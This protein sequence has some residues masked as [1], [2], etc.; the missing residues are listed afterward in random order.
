MGEGRYKITIEMVA[1]GFVAHVAAEDHRECD[2][3]GTYVFEGIDGLLEFI[4]ERCCKT[5]DKS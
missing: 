1:N 3:N 4:S 5:E 2:M